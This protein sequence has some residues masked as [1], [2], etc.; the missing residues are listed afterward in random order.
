MNYSLHW[1]TSF[2]RFI[3][4][5]RFLSRPQVNHHDLNSSSNWRNELMHRSSFHL[6][7]ISVDAVTKKA[8]AIVTRPHRIQSLSIGKCWFLYSVVACSHYT[9][10]FAFDFL[11]PI[12]LIYSASALLLPNSHIDGLH[13]EFWYVYQKLHRA[14]ITYYM[15]PNEWPYTSPTMP[16]CYLCRLWGTFLKFSIVVGRRIVAVRLQL[17]RIRRVHSKVHAVC[18]TNTISKADKSSQFIKTNRIEANTKNERKKSTKNATTYCGI[19][20]ETQENKNL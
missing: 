12:S 1:C 6:V 13:I 4:L 16:P 9:V 20:R 8:A 14:Q 18:R 11:D 17:P 19:S 2:D 15:P 5:K 7:F 10:F 3:S